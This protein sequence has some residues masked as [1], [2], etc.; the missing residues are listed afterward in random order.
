[1]K[2]VLILIV[3]AAAVVLSAASVGAGFQA[4]APSQADKPGRAAVYSVSDSDLYCSFFI[5]E[6][7]PALRIAA[8]SDGRTLFADGDI[9]SLAGRGLSAVQAGQVLSVL[10][11]GP[12]VDSLSRNPSP[13]RLAFQRGRVRIL[14]VQGDAG[15]A[16]VEKTC[17]SLTPGCVLAPFLERTRLQVKESPFAAFSREAGVP[18]GRV[19]YVEGDAVQIATDQR[20]LIDIGR[21]AGL[22]VGRQLT[23]FAPPDGGGDRPTEPSANAVVIDA[24]AA[25]ATV[26]ILTAK[27]P[28]LIGDLVQVK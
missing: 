15:S 8:S 22:D 2:N 21:N 27:A 14:S 25:S 6:A 18:T 19:L 1:M 28:V 4:P 24:G 10:E 13:G 12:K 20:A 5:L 3:I 11:I 16:R 26:K 17:G 7:E 9:V 23:V